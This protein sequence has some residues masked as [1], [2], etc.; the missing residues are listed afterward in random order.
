MA[1]NPP[2]SSV[3]QKTLSGVPPESEFPSPPDERNDEEKE[4]QRGN[5]NGERRAIFSVCQVASYKYLSDEVYMSVGWE[6]E[7]Q[8][9]N[10]QMET[11]S[12]VNLQGTSLEGLLIRKSV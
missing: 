3:A 6:P 8:G 11:F 10:I 12:E 2:A 9:L 4:V 1:P 5:G 7:R